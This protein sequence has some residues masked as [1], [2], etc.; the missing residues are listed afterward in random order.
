[1]NEKK[2]ILNR[3]LPSVAN[4]IE[5][6]RIKAEND[7][8]RLENESIRL[9]QQNAAQMFRNPDGSSRKH[10]FAGSSK[11][12]AT[13]GISEFK[14]T[15]QTLRML[16][17]YYESIGEVSTSIKM[18]A[19]NAVMVGYDLYCE[20]PKALEEVKLFIDRVD[21]QSV[22]LEAVKYALIFGDSFT[23][24][25]PT[26]GNTAGSLIS[27]D[28]TTID[29]ELDTS[30][31]GAILNKHKQ[32]LMKSKGQVV[33]TF[34]PD[35]IMPLGFYSIPGSPYHLSLIVPALDII[36]SKKR[37]DEA[38]VH[39]M[40]LHGTPK[41][42]AKIGSPDYND[43]NP[44]PEDV[45]KD[46][47][48]ELEDITHKNEFVSSY[49]VNIDT[50]DSGGVEHVNEYWEYFQNQLIVALL[51]NSSMLGYAQSVT[52]ASSRTLQIQYERMIRDIQTKLERAIEINIFDK[53]TGTRFGDDTHVKIKFRGVTEENEVLVAEWMGRIIRYRPDVF[54]RDEIRQRF[55][56]APY[57]EVAHD[58]EEIP[59]QTPQ[60]QKP[61]QE[62]EDD[63]RSIR[64]DDIKPNEKSFQ[65]ILREMVH[66]EINRMIK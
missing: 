13:T 34:K 49:L 51:T 60:P 17:S 32:Y 46:F 41:Y 45:L 23:Y 57:A 3:V 39:A 16:F 20:N 1:M 8:I 44:P 61:P 54:T 66:D 43:G 42:H 5:T 63:D 6:S 31:K 36:D 64:E 7:R 58:D 19:W 40:E 53:I 27:L 59:E 37:V 12:A 29:I 21:L 18:L 10:L 52:E 48:T 55:G 28:P 30:K 47:K 56:L 25:T 22:M 14:R 9:K 11:G 26:K 24:I 2:G 15:E 62:Q 33:E 65:R 35:E 50:L 4:R 38:L